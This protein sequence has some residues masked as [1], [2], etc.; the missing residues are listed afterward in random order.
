MPA[1][2]DT[3]LGI[4]LMI[5]T[6]LIFAIQDGI[7]RYLAGHYNILT[8]VTIRYWFFAAFAM[9]ITA[10]RAGGLRKAAQT[11]RPW[12]QICRGVLLVTQICLA[13]LSFVLLGLIETQAI[14]MVYPLLIAA[15]AGP[16]LGEY[17]GWRR[18]LA[19]LI[20]LAGVLI[21][22]RPGM[23]AFSAEAIL[24]LITALIFAVYGLLT[25]IVGRDDS[26][27]TSFFYTGV[28]GAV[29]ITLIGPFFWTPISGVKDWAWMCTLCC[30]GVAGHFL[31]IKVYEVAEAGS[32]Q[33]FAY[34]QLLF[35]TIIGVSVFDERPDIW[36]ILGGAM[37]LSA[38]VYTLIRMAR[39][40]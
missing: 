28:A 35:V 12:L 29:A 2:N 32:V 19:I 37:I 4:M 33:P 14:F 21:I 6:T 30:T 27:A 25:R 16:V 34:F 20:G 36:T 39:K 38:G 9:S 11:K 23:R 7:S 8:I 24:P 3:R 1:R 40:G 22:L 31:L 15:L 26:A 13:V 10:H 17:V 5:L 18:T